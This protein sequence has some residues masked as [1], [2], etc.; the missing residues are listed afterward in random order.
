HQPPDG[1]ARATTNVVHW[2]T[3]IGWCIQY[4]ALADRT[5]RH[6][7]LRAVSLGPLVW[8]SGYVLLPPIG[9]YQPIWKYDATTLAKDLS[10]HLVFGAAASATFALLH[11]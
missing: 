2:A 9:V 1:W 5:S 10:G 11:D 8:L 6:P 3:G 4:G 7:L